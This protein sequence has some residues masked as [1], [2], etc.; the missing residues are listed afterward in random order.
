MTVP[1]ERER[2][3][4]HPMPSPT[5][6]ARMFVHHPVTAEQLADLARFSG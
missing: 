3:L 6:Q 1:V 2:R 4:Y 5:H